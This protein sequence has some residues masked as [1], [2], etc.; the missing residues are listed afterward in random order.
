MPATFSFGK[1]E[2]TTDTAQSSARSKP[3]PDVPFRIALLAD[4]SNGGSQATKPRPGLSRRRPVLIDR[5]NFNQVLAQIG[6][7][8]QLPAGIA[9]REAVKLHMSELEDFHPDRIF[10]QVEAFQMLDDLRQRLKNPVT[11][12]AAAAEMRAL[13]E[14]PGASTMPEEP[15]SAAKQSEVNASDLLEQIIDASPGQKPPV[16]PDEILGD[17]QGYLR[18]LV[19]PH[20]VPQSH[21]QAQP[22]IAHIEAA[23]EEQMR[24][25]LHYPGFQALEAAWR[26]VFFLTHRLETGNELKLYLVDVSKAELAADLTSSEDL[27][28]TGLYRLLVKQSVEAPGDQP[29]AVLAGNYTFDNSSEDAEL[30]GRIAKVAARAGA[31][32]LAAASPKILGCDSLTTTPDPDD[33]SESTDP[34]VLEIWK[35]VRELPE[36]SH[37]GLS[38][39]GLLLRLPYGKETEPI[40]RFPFEE[41]A[42]NPDHAHYLWGNPA[43]ACVYLLAEAF[44]RDGW[45]MRP[46]I[47][48]EIAG[49]PLHTYQKDGESL[50]KPCSEALLSERAAERMLDQGVMPLLSFHGRD[51][52]RLARFQSLASP[53]KPIA[54]RWSG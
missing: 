43:F 27:T 35:A 7:E 21:P 45:N 15:A 14:I 20:L 5:D 1:I 9:S 38:L 30:L 37:V 40:E 19:A 41:I 51:A 42:K 22:L 23:M 32:F 49:L 29:W 50:I 4:F 3:K 39:P 28:S 26:G 54:G 24:A 34:Q 6:I 48:R 44:S 53:L 17:W 16:R 25:I 33:W 13:M 46:G 18:R 36:A 47:V 52:V 11:F 12:A 31:P 10:A 2:L 8:V